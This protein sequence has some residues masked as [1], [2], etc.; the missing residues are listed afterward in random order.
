MNPDVPTGDSGDI[1]RQ[2]YDYLYSHYLGQ[3]AQRTGVQEDTLLWVILWIFIFASLFYAYTRW[4]RT[5]RQQREPYPVESYNGYI[6][7][8]NGPVGTFLTLFF[9]TMFIFL[10][11]MTVLSLMH[12]Q[13]Y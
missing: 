12:G 13:I 7:E 1:V 4:Q 8:G 2:Y 5:T 11:I 6:E 3:I 9:I 10:I